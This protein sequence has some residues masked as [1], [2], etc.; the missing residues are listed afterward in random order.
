MS[1][2]PLVP[3]QL[4][5]VSEL[6]Q[7]TNQFNLTT[8]R[9]SEA[10]V[11]KL[12]RLREWECLVVHVKDRFGDYGLV[13]VIIFEVDSDAIIVDTFL[14]S[15][16]SLGRGVEHQMLVRLGEIARERELDSIKV[17]YMPTQKNRP[18]H[19]FL[20]GIGA[21][22]K[23]PFGNGFAFRF[24]TEF[25]VGVRYRPPVVE[26]AGELPVE[27]AAPVLAPAESAANTRAKAALWSSIA[28]ELYSAEQIQKVIS[29][30]TQTRPGT[31]STLVP[32]RTPVEKIVA[33]LWSELLGFEQVGINDNFFELGGHSLL[34][35]QVL[36]RMRET[37]QVELPLTLLFNSEF[38]VAELAKAVLIEQIRQADPQEIATML[39]NLEQLSEENAQALLASKERLF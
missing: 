28:A 23:E 37:F 36:S 1:S 22:F 3:H 38:T 27:R 26:G 39:N 24:P 5:R 6:T 31:K 30:Q 16:R 14:L 18:A 10:E 33:E 34:A 9:R 35:M 15:C 8:V 7:R 19:D 21:R 20:Q 32:P 11:Q 12:C 13:G 17:P 4:A 25:A 2:F 29:A